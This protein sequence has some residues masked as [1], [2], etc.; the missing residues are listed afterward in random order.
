MTVVDN[1]HG[2]YYTRLHVATPG[3]EVITI[4]ND[5]FSAAANTLT[6]SPQ[7]RLSP[8]CRACQE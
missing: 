8:R 7:A 6:S 5:L 2:K 1:N 3:N 4:V